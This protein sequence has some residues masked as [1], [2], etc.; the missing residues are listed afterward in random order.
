MRLECGCGRTYRAP[1]HDCPACGATLQALKSDAPRRPVPPGAARI[2]PEILVR[3]KLALRDE[4]RARDRQLRRLELRVRALQAELDVLKRGPALVAAPPV[5]VLE[6][7]IRPTELPS[8][9]PDLS[10]L[11][12]TEETPALQNAVLLPDDRLPL[13]DGD[14]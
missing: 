1:D 13:F 14:D 7:A 4:L 6:T 5:R 8:D 2:D 10:L 11:P 9:R 3:Q 12:L